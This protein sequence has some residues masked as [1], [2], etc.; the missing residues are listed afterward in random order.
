MC[1]R[2]YELLPHVAVDAGLVGEALRIGH[3]IDALLGVAALDARCVDGHQLLAFCSLLRLDETVKH[4][5]IAGHL[6]DET[7][8]LSAFIRLL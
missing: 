1:F 6:I 5:L 7:E 3:R 2:T 8:I 4:L